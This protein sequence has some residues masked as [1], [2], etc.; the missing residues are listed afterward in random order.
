MYCYGVLC[1]ARTEAR[2]RRFVFATLVLLEW[3]LAVGWVFAVL[4]QRL[5][6]SQVRGVHAAAAAVVASSFWFSACQLML[7][8]ISS[9]VAAPN[10]SSL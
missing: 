3:I 8:G 5:C 1:C 9:S 2:L 4:L 6:N 7:H 10:S